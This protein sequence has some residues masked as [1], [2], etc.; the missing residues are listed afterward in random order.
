MFRFDIVR[1]N[2]KEVS[3]KVIHAK[4]PRFINEKI[5]QCIP[6]LLLL[7]LAEMIGFNQSEPRYFLL[8]KHIDYVYKSIHETGSYR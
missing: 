2:A 6:F 5:K 1:I 4:K 3:K 7:L 8:D